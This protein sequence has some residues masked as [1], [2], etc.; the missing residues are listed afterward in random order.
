[1]TTPH[2]KSQNAVEKRIAEIELQINS[3]D[4][5]DIFDIGDV[6]FLIRELKKARA[7]NAHFKE[8]G[9]HKVWKD[10][11][12][13]L[14]VTNQANLRKLERAESILE[15]ARDSLG[16]DQS[17]VH[18]A[19]TEFLAEIQTKAGASCPHCGMKWG[20]EQT[21]CERCRRSNSRGA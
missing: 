5:A 6:A 13:A 17:V 8:N 20:V 12:A 7:E 10:D 3:H 9:V 4:D 16:I 14:A 21:N 18:G 2:D 11:H 19:I 15:L 1:M